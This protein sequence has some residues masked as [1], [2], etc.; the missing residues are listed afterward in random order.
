MSEYVVNIVILDV[1]DDVKE[2]RMFVKGDVDMDIVSAHDSLIKV[3]EQMQKKLGR[4]CYSLI[5]RTEFRDY[6][7]VKR[8]SLI[9]KF[10]KK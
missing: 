3:A 6:D 4:K 9:G 10:S 2:V 7:S 1:T 8:V 5:F